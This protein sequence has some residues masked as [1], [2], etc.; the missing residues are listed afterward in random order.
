MVGSYIG[1]DGIMAMAI[2]VKI[3]TVV[4]MFCSGDD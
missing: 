1:D 3:A 4:N 2:V